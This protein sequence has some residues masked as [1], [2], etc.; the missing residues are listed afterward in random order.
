MGSNEVVE[1]T[2]NEE[3]EKVPETEELPIKES[4]RNAIKEVDA[5]E[6]TPVKV[7]EVEQPIK[8]SGRKGPMKKTT[9]AEDAA[10]EKTSTPVKRAGRKVASSVFSVQEEKPSEEVVPEMSEQT[11][12]SG[13]RVA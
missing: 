11:K 9:D 7:P 4:K 6:S 1:N 8:K 13:R 10:T 3:E 12:K 5:S 2:I